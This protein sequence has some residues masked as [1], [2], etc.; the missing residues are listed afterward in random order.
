[1][2]AKRPDNGQRLQG[3]KRKNDKLLLSVSEAQRILSIGET[4][5]KSLIRGGQIRSVKIGSKRGRRLISRAALEE[6]IASN[7]TNGW[8]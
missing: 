3:E 8:K 5:L 2:E 7:E 6:F 4:L 1:M